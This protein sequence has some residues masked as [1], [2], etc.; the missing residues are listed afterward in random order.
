VLE[1]FEEKNPR[2]LGGEVEAT[3]VVEQVREINQEPKEE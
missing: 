2:A 3:S 1:E